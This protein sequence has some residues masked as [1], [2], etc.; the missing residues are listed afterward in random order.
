MNTGARQSPM[1]TAKPGAA[2]SARR[3][4][5]PPGRAAR[6]SAVWTLLLA[7]FM[8]C[9]WTGCEI[10]VTEQNY[11]RLSFWFDGVPD[12]NAPV[13]SA[14]GGGGGGRGSTR[15]AQGQIVSRHKPFVEQKC[16]ECHTAKGDK[17]EFA[18]ATASCARCHEKVARQYPV[19]HG[20]VVSGACLWCHR[21]HDSTMPAL[22]RADSSQLC[23]QC[24]DRRVLSSETAEHQ[25]EKKGC[26]DCHTGHGGTDRRMLKAPGTP[27]GPV[28]QPATQPAPVPTI[29]PTAT[30]EKGG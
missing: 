15:P 29:G 1:D 8:A 23:T 18:L 17:P 24:H 28:T 10:K 16:N 20:P 19:M 3:R 12:P 25:A 21:P 13:A 27:P 22:L 6:M 30:T 11:K 5:A 2:R 7:V 26:L 14:R 4:A 9:F